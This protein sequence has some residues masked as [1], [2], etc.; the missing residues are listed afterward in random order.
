MGPEAAPLA[1]LDGYPAEVRVAATNQDSYAL[2]RLRAVAPREKGGQ[3]DGS[4]GLGH[5]TQR[6]PQR[7]LRLAYRRVLHEHDAVHVPPGDGEGETTG[8][9]RAQGVCGETA[10]LDVDR[11]TGPECCVQGRGQLRLDARRRREPRRGSRRPC[12]R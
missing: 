9:P 1:G 11:L 6:P 12:P 3:R 8:P 4:T 7:P 2:T 5:E 10:G